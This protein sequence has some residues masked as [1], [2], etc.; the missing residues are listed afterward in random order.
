MLNCFVCDRGW[1]LE[2]VAEHLFGG[3]EGE[4]EAVDE[5]TAEPPPEGFDAIDA[6]E[7]L[8]ESRGFPD[9]AGALGIDDLY[10]DD[11][12]ESPLCGYLIFESGG[13]IVGR[14]LVG[15]D[16]P[17]YKNSVGS[18]SAFRVGRGGEGAAWLVEGVTDAFALYLAGVPT[19]YALLGCKATD[20]QAYAM[21]RHKSV[22]VCLDAD[23]AG[24]KG[25]RGVVETLR[26]YGVKATI[27]ELPTARGWSDPA[28]AWERDREGFSEWVAAEMARYSSSD[29]GYVASLFVSRPMRVLSTGIPSW[30]SALGGGFGFG[31]HAL[32]A[33]PGV[34]KTSF[35]LDRL[36]AWARD[37]VR[38]LYVTYEISKRQA[39]ARLASAI[40]TR[41][42]SEI[43]LDPRVLEDSAREELLRLSSRIRVGVGW[44]ADEVAVA[45]QS[46]DAIVVDYLQRMPGV[47]EDRKSIESNISDLAD[48]GRDQ[49][50]VVLVISALPR[51]GYG[52]GFALDSF[53]DTGKI[54]YVVQS[55]SG[56]LRTAQQG[57]L[58]VKV[59]KNS[60]G[61]PSSGAFF[62]G[63]DLGHIAF[64]E[65]EIVE[66]PTK[67]KIRNAFQGGT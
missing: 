67:E 16:R 49:E 20:A 56:L 61:A 30:D 22:H 9:T 24:Y 41:T 18:K 8:L 64:E 10:V 27:H 39:W 13:Q 26:E 29:S 6:A 40:S 4:A 28:D 42:W 14:D 43:E 5:V 47:E 60:R 11:S 63:T 19:V 46:Y 62:V 52:D 31:A 2:T 36:F 50:K 12:P 37:G 21:R 7:K 58:R 59:V 53:R 35:A 25:A 54:E 15:G 34:G 55:A 3:G 51:R 38:G 45:A 44:T 65:I 48:I 17:R 66:N 1:R 33:E 32:G 23:A 57:V